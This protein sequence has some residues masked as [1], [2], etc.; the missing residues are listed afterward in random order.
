MPHLFLRRLLAASPT[1]QFLAEME[2][3]LGGLSAN[4]RSVADQMAKL[5]ADAD[6][7]I[8]N[9]RARWSERRKIIEDT[10]EKLLRE[11]QKSKIDGA[12]FIRLREQIEGLRPLAGEK[13]HTK[14][15]LGRK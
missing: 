12:E 10:Y 4:L 14:S 7:V 5:L 8:A 13:R 15:R 1:R 11:L 9:T 6:K 2:S 3:T